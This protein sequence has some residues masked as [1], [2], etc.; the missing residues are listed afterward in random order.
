MDPLP[1]RSRA[2]VATAPGT[3]EPRELPMPRIGPDDG[4]LRVEAAGICGTDWELYPRESRGR[5]P[6]ILGHENVGQVVA[7]GEQRSVAPAIELIRSDRFPLRLLC[8]H[9]FGL[10]GVDHAL[11]VAGARLDREAIHVS[12]V[13]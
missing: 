6:L 2:A 5:G 4:L 9:A 12:I 1:A 7:L 11:R 8:T 13:P 3:T 10:H